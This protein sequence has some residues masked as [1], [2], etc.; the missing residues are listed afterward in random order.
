[1]TAM[2]LAERMDEREMDLWFAEG[3]LREEERRDAELLARAK[4]AAMRGRG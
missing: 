2:E 3:L 4:A 1:M